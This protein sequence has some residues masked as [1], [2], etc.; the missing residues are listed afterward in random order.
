MG[1]CGSAVDAHKYDMEQLTVEV[2]NGGTVLGVCYQPH[3]IKEHYWLRSD[4][5]LKTVLR[6]NAQAKAYVSKGKHAVYPIEGRIWR[7]GGV[8]ND[9]CMHPR[10]QQMRVELPSDK[11]LAEDYI[12]SV[13]RSINRR[14]HHVSGDNR[15]CVPLRTARTRMVFG[16]L[17][18]AK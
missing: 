13:F 18:S 12:D 10:S 2:S 16:G 5:D 14:M 1:C 11:V 7:Y 8:A 6:G 9:V 17:G 4:S 15:P 3:G